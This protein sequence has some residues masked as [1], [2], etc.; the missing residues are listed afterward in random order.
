MQELSKSSIDY[1]LLPNKIFCGMAGMW[2]VDEKSSTGIKLFAYFRLVFALTA[3]SSVFI[4]E[5]LVIVV[6]WG[7]LKVL[8]GNMLKRNCYLNY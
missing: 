2:P 8:A 1:Y 4:P 6:N 7:D 3:V 5:I